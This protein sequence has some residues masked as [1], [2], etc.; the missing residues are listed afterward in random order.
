MTWPA[1][2]R[3]LPFLQGVDRAAFAVALATRL[4]AHDVPVGFT[5]IDDVVRALAAAPPDSRSRLYWTTRVTLVRR[6]VDLAAFDAIFAAV[7]QDATLEADPHARRRPPPGPGGEADTLLP[8]AVSAP[9]PASGS[10]LPWATLPQVVATATEVDSPTLVPWR[11]PSTLEEAADRPFDE[12]DPREVALLGR[13]LESVAPEWP[14]RR[15]RRLSPDRRGH[16]VALRPTVARARHTAWEPVDLVGLRPVLKPRRVVMLCDVSQSMQAQAVAYLHLMRALALGA[17]AEVFAFATSL[18]R[19]TSVLGQ[20]SAQ[21]A[22]AQASAKVTDRF[23]GTRIATNIQSLLAS[24]HGGVVRGAVVII[25]SDG[26][27][28][29]SPQEL[30]A[31]MARLRRRA[32]RVVWMNPRAG[33][34]GFEPQVATMAAALPYC[35]RLVPADTFRS[36][37]GVVHEIARCSRP[38]ERVQVVSSRA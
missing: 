35:D 8:L 14:R 13:W 3:A 28:S 27:D 22:I 29:D 15:S 19:L 38:A 37:V 7:F 17:D 32:Y 33:A 10:G 24:H 31:A 26:W 12:L 6:Q 11:L 34:P 23:G 16:R 4:R 25:A 30:A 9:G 36:L 21:V 1:S 5:A 2:H 18:T 20:R